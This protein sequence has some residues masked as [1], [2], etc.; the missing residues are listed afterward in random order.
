MEPFLV[1]YRNLL[2][3]LALLA[4]Q[5]VGLATQVHRADSGRMSLDPR[6]TGGVRLLR[7]WAEAVVAP[8][9]RVFHFAG[10]GLT[11]LWRN[12]VDLRHV[13]EQTS[14]CSGPS[15][16]S[17][18]SRRRCLRMPARVSACRAC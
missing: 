12:Y 1:R 16:G 8:P 5:I 3:L 15:T 9:E 4:V 14:S 2:V 17:A 11:A 6:D 10:S 18:L 13:R 7:M